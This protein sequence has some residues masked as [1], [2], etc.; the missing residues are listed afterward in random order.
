LSASAQRWP[1]SAVA[2][3]IGVESERLNKLLDRGV[4]ALS[5]AAESPGSGH[6]REFSLR[7]I[8]RAA[9]VNRL[10]NLGL[11]PGRARTLAEP[12]FAG[13]D[14]RAPGALFGSGRTV[15]RCTAAGATVVHVQ[16]GQRIDGLRDEGAILLNLDLV[17]VLTNAK[18]GI[19]TGSH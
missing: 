3:A 1:A 5:D 8:H 11:P 4:I 16:P 19:P 18:L 2:V 14:G 17:V 6:Y 7:D 10:I 9:I 15:L 12:F 13:G